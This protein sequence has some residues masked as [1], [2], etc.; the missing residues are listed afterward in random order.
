MGSDQT[1]DAS[2]SESE[3]EIVFNVDDVFFK[4]ILDGLE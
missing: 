1:E 3:I 2:N 4:K